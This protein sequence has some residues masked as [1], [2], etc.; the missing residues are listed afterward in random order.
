MITRKDKAQ[1]VGCLVITGAVAASVGVEVMFGDGWG[2]LFAA[3]SFLT[4][5]LLVSR[6]VPVQN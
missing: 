3:G 4:M 6:L 1:S 5:G 2:W